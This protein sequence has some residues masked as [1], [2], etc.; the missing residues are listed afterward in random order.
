MDITVVNVPHSQS[1]YY[2]PGWSS[3]LTGIVLF[4]I[5]FKVYKSLVTCQK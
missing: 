1:A 2:V 3:W 5:L 4:D